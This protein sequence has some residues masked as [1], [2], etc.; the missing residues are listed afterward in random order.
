[1][2][3]EYMALWKG[4]EEYFKSILA[5]PECY[6]NCFSYFGGVCPVFWCDTDVGMKANANHLS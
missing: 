1:M 3:N 5:F 4:R 2:R 6:I